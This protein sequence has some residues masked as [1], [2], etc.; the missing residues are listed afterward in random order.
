KKYLLTKGIPQQSAPTPPGWTTENPWPSST[1]SMARAVGTTTSP[2]RA[3]RIRVR[4]LGK[5]T[6]RGEPIAPAR[7]AAGG[8]APVGRS[9]PRRSRGTSSGATRWRGAVTRS[10][11]RAPPGIDLTSETARSE[12]R[13][14]AATAPNRRAARRATRRVAGERAAAFISFTSAPVSIFTGHD[15]LHI[16]SPAHVRAP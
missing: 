7:G 15:V 8:G 11:T 4:Q 5:Y 14:P 10:R 13:A 9:I 2:G 12:Q 1:S 16:E 6:T 3:P